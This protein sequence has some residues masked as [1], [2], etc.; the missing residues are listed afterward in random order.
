MKK[1]AVVCASCLL[2][3]FSLIHSS[4]AQ[5]STGTPPFSS[6]GGGPFDTVN[7]GN[8]NVHFAAPVIHRAG[9]G[10][11]FNYNISYDSSIWA[12]VTVNGNKSW[13]PAT[14]WGWGGT[15]APTTGYVSYTSVNSGNACF[16]SG[17]YY[18]QQ[19][20]QSNW[21]Y[22]DPYGA[23]HYFAGTT[24]HYVGSPAY[25]P[26]DTS[27][28]SLTSDGSGWTLVAVGGT[29]NKV[30]AI[31]GLVAHP[32][33]NGT[34]G[35]ASVIDANG[36]EI[37]ADNSGNF[38]DTLSGTSAVLTVTGNGS[39]TSPVKLQYTG[40]GG[41][42]PYYQ[43]IY[44]SYNVKTQFLC[45]GVTDYTST[46][47]IYLV[48]SIILPDNS[49][50]SFSYEATPNNSGYVTGRVSQVTLPTGGTI[51]YNYTY[52]GSND[53]IN[54]S[55]GSTLVLQRTVNGGNSETAGTWKYARSGSGASWN[56]IV[57][58]PNSNDTAISFEEAGS[59][60]FYE[61]QRIAYQG[62]HTS[63]TPV[64]T[65]I[66]CY[67]GQNVSNPAT[68]YNTAITPT[69]SRITNFQYLP[70][71]SGLQAE[72]DSYFDTSGYGL[73]TKKDEYNYGNGAVGSLIRE[74]VTSYASLGNGIV[75]RPS[76]VALYDSTTNHGSSDLKAY[77]AYTY[78]QYTPT[79]TGATQHVSVTGSRGN[80][81]TVQA[82]T[83]PA[84]TYLY[85]RYTYF[86]TGM[87]AS[88]QDVNTWTT[89]YTYSSTNNASCNY[90]FVTS[91][92]EPVNS[93]TRQFQWDCNGGVPKQITDENGN[94]ATISYGT[95]PFWRPTSTTDFLQNATSYSYSLT[96]SSPPVEYQ[97]EAKSAQFGNSS[98]KSILD[99][100]VTADGFGRP[101]FSQTKQSPS[102]TNYDTT[103]TCYDSFGR[104]SFV[105]IPYATTLA[106]S[107]TTCPSS[108]PGASYSYNNDAL[109]L[110]SS[111]SQVLGSGTETVSF[112]Y[113]KNDVTATV[114]SPTI[115]R[116]YEVDAAGRLSSVCEVTAGTSSWPN[117]PCSQNTTASGYL[118][119]YT[120]DLL[121]NLSGVTQNAQSSTN[122]Q[123]RT[124][125]YDMLSR[126]TSETNPETGNQPIN[127]AYDS[128]SNPCG[129]GQYND[130]GNLIRRTDPNNN[131]V[132]YQNDAMHRLIAVGNS[133]QSATNPIQYFRYD[134][135]ST[136]VVSQPSGST[137]SNVAGR[138]MEAYT[139][140]NGTLTDVWYS[141]DANG[142]P[143]DIWQSTQ[144]SGGYFHSQAT[145]PWPNGA[146]NAFS[147]KNPSGSLIFPTIY[148]GASDGSGLDG[149]GRVT[150]VTASSGTT[151]VN[152]ATYASSTGGSAVT[153]SLTGLTFG[154]GD[155][156]TFTYDAQSG[157]QTGYTFS[158]NGTTDIGAMTWNLNG[159]LQAFNIT[160]HLTGSSDSG[161]C[162]YYYDDLGRLA[163]KD[164]SGYSVDCGSGKLQDL[165][166]FDPFGNINKSG[167]FTFQPSYDVSKNQFNPGT[168]GQYDA[169]GNLTQDNLGQ[170]Y[171]WNVFGNPSTINGIT[172][173]YDPN[174][175]IVE[176]QNGSSNTPIL[177]TQLGKT[178]LLN[179]STLTKALVPLPGGETAI[180]NSSGLAYYRHAD[181][182]GSSRLTTTSSRTVYSV[183]NYG[184]YGEVVSSSPNSDPSFTGQN[185]DT[186]STL[187]DFPFREHSPSQGRWLSPDPAG[188]TA[189]D[190]LDPQS[191]NRYAYVGNRTMN[192]VDPLGLDGCEPGDPFCCVD[193]TDPF[194]CDPTDPW[195]PPCIYPG[196]P[197]GGG[198]GSGEGSPGGGGY[199]PKSDWP[200]GETLGLPGGL[201]VHPLGNLGSLFGLLPNIGCGD[202]IAC[203]SLGP[204]GD[205]FIGTGQ[206]GYRIHSYWYD[207]ADDLV[208][209]Y[210]PYLHRWR[211]AQQI[212]PRYSVLQ[213]Q[214]FCYDE[215]AMGNSPY[216]LD[217]N[218]EIDIYG[219][220]IGPGS[221][222]GN[223]T[224]IGTVLNQNTQHGD[225]VMQPNGGATAQTVQAGVG[226]AQ[227]ITSAGAGKIACSNI[228]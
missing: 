29:V 23:V 68:C 150:K 79:N 84:P 45:N 162:N 177:R 194:C 91:I 208:F 210:R 178:A 26:A 129:W 185:P 125:A 22:H 186:I 111:V 130:A 41:S 28:T 37:T 135:V 13:Q 121:D 209:A 190:P 122:Q 42:A 34:G 164:A 120:Y 86:D 113:N 100:Y 128:D 97:A 180:Y 30:T 118:T 136:G 134:N 159:T 73:I 78:D 173:V 88:S 204:F 50:Y 127:Y 70:T 206:R 154:T 43:I 77:T 193:P 202:F 225:R 144:H 103:A 8:L 61:T 184:P 138:L 126:L 224:A 199:N 149:E 112:N 16:F 21:A 47:A 227:R 92:A 168:Y 82:Q 25:C 87:L 119:K 60:N 9:R 75:D 166:T 155:S 2:F 24:I 183:T 179:G 222:P 44:G 10:M 142:N 67:N 27:L 212:G 31:S 175:Q 99:S 114:S 39:P 17:S 223:Q 59:S 226:A 83:S 174:G 89:T 213:R 66:N 161:N 207:W 106:T 95:D 96:T 94:A 198:G 101:L 141:Y 52:T 211:P 115:T 153:G 1:I 36:N 123:T 110:L 4:S 38:F 151:P 72:T 145:F 187:Y 158:V 163:G 181:W 53:G 157:R 85:R 49:Q 156:D 104:I 171:A 124:Y 71:A 51:S 18:G 217:S 219:N 58:D 35:S 139:G 11:S 90:A 74:T 203:G 221:D 14:N 201:N 192:T 109:G 57:T 107:G 55:D 189:V 220:P 176:Q 7:L 63:G 3:G 143:T 81:T 216:D 215:V 133:N 146:I 205:E 15:T 54:C 64:S 147:I 182:L 131:S 200:N 46:S 33:V 132:C 160:D 188:L 48:N 152:S 65:S 19:Y 169:D 69:I 148:Y 93:M 195:G 105:T 56:T 228:K 218:S 197:G 80:L 140:W 165:Y 76:S 98:T 137:I 108:N 102:A 12:P 172:A 170:Q 167:T 191:W 214:T 6:M 40:A 20:T 116:Q 117:G 32:P 196:P 5:V 62:N